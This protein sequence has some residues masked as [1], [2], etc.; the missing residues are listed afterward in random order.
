M[1]I[2]R[3]LPRTL[4]EQRHV[5]TVGPVQPQQH[6]DRRRLTCPVRPQ[7]TVNLTLR[8]LQVQL[9]EC[10]D[11]TKRLPQTRVPY[12]WSHGGQTTPVSH[13]FELCVVSIM[14]LDFNIC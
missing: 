13:F 2:R 4:A 8:D 5:T 6:P 3:P 14:P 7:E 1:K 11:W 10:E 12:H 9:V